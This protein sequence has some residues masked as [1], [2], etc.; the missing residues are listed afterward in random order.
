M[1]YNFYRILVMILKIES[2]KNSIRDFVSNSFSSIPAVVLKFCRYTDLRNV[3]K[4]IL[5]SGL[6]LERIFFFVVV[7]VAGK[8]F[9][10]VSCL[11]TSLIYTLEY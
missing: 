4:C 5:S 10:A 1:C 8:G 7:I 11:K 2:Y 6:T 9:K 3:S